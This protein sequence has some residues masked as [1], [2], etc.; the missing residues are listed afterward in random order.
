[1]EV[2]ETEA[3]VEAGGFVG[4]HQAGGPAIETVGPVVES[5]HATLANGDHSV[6]IFHMTEKGRILHTRTP[7][8][9]QDTR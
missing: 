6:P 3:R 2:P 4:V 5:V 1:V 9:T 8:D 7:H